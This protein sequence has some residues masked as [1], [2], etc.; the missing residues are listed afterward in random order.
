MR[1]LLTLVAVV[2]LAL[3]AHSQDAHRRVS[4]AL[5]EIHENGRAIYNNNDDYTGAYRMFQGGLMFAR[6][7][8]TDRPDVQKLISDGLAAA[9]R[10]PTMDRRAFRLHEL[11]ETVRTELG[12]APG[13]S[14]DKLTVPPRVIEPAKPATKAE[15]KPG[16]TASEVKDGVVGRVLAQ[17][18]PVGG[19][20]VTFVTLGQQPPRVFETVSSPQGV[21][22]IPSLPAGK[23]IILITPG[24]NATVKK[25]PDRYATSTNSPL[26]FDVK[27]NGEKLDFVLQ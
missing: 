1:Y 12:K 2:G 10:Q 7:M 16:A 6:R 5:L 21:Y 4:D 8:L 3:T 11:I 25:L 23:Y 20:E 14:A 22:T 24:P 26:V 18:A 13:K 9:E 15:A 17:G 27:G 19:V